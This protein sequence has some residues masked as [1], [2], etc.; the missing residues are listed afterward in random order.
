MTVSLI[1]A[2]KNRAKPLR[3]SLSSWLLF[4]QIK[5]IIIVDWDSDEP[6]YD[7]AKI[8]E[9]I[10]II[11]VDNE[12][13]FNQSQPLNLASK[14]VTSENLLKVS[15]DY[16]LNPYFNFFDSYSL[17]DNEF[18]MGFNTLEK[19]AFLYPLWGFL[20]VKRCHFNAVG[21]Y[22]ENLGKYYS[23]EDSELWLRLMALGLTPKPIKTTKLTAIHILHSDKKRVE[24]LE[25]F[26]KIEQLLI[27]KMGGESKDS[28]YSHMVKLSKKKN[29]EE[30]P[31]CEKMYEMLSDPDSNQNIK[32][33]MTPYH[34]PIY[35]W[36]LKKI[37]NQI[38]KAV[39]V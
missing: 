21:G 35:E 4:D 23:G 2:C 1:C 27:E 26:G 31:D 38:Y 11:R 5:E 20:Y 32:F 36:N 37:D 28:L 10:K 19:D 39:K 25:S 13:Y 14:L 17:E 8:D 15:C 9:R 3:I 30:Y 34:K 22:N 18:I 12:K 29:L 24:H 7:F 33:D 6:I 16:I